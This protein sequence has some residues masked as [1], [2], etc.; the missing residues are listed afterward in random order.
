MIPYKYLNSEAN[1]TGLVILLI[2]IC[3][4][5]AATAI[6]IWIS[7]NISKPLK[8]IAEAMGKAENGNLRV[9]AVIQRKDELGEVSDSFN[10][11][12]GSISTLISKVGHSTGNVAENA[13]LVSDASE[14]NLSSSEQIAL[15]IQEIAKGSEE[16]ATQASK[17][18]IHMSAL[19]S[20]INRVGEKMKI[21][22][23]NVY[24]SKQLSE[25]SQSILDTLN[26]KAL[27]T[28]SASC[29]VIN[30]IND[31]NSQMKEIKKI[32]KIIMGISD[33]TNLLA[34]NAAIEAA[35]AGSAG[36]GF[37][38]VAEEVGKLA[39]QI[40]N[41]TGTIDSIIK[42]VQTSTENAVTEAD[43]TGQIVSQQLDVVK[44]TAE[45][46]R[47]IFGSMVHI[48]EEMSNLDGSIQS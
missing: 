27:E 13:I 37:A 36:K 26:K 33:E 17:S 32:I 41:A 15:T 28:S 9:N 16:Q 20:E 10:H 18:V 7:G 34:F 35:R 12:I 21:V 48:S 39:N 2:G 44:N 31:L 24:T 45:A 40:K 38:V 29:N 43:H 23:D 6:S 14:Q 22:S 4:L 8:K 30:H 19:S 1:K 42:K 47:T 11:M 46:F 5:I 25:D 3:C